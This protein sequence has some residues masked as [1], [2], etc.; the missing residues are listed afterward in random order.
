V[1]TILPLPATL[2]ALQGAPKTNGKPKEKMNGRQEEEEEEEEKSNQRNA[3]V[4]E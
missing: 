3:A 4:T 2:P 1:T